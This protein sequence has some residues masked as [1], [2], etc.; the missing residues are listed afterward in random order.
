MQNGIEVTDR[1]YFKDTFSEAELR[2]LAAMAG[3]ENI[4]ARRSPSLKKM[5]LADK[6][7]SDDEMVNLMLQEPK[8][9]RRPMMKIGGKLVVGGGNAAMEEAIAAAK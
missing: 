4:F 9:V 3:T 8:L 6:D 1:D 5:G 2:E 7:L